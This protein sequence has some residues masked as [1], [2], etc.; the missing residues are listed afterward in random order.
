MRTRSFSP[1]IYAHA[2]NIGTQKNFDTKDGFDTATDFDTED[3]FDTAIVKKIRK[4]Q[5][6][7]KK[8]FV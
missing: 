6:W 4:F 2:Q 3:S 1:S 7:T 8:T 5:Y